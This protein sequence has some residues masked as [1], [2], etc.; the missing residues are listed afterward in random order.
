MSQKS[1]LPVKLCLLFVSIITTLST[2]V[3]SAG[4]AA[5]ECQGEEHGY[6]DGNGAEGGAD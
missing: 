5:D 2:G 3:V 4:G 6:A 1:C